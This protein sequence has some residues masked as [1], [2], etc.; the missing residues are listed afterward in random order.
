MKFFESFVRSQMQFLNEK[1]H[2]RKHVKIFRRTMHAVPR[3][4]KRLREY[5]KSNGRHCEHLL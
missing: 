4:R 5:V 3:F 1:S 2:W